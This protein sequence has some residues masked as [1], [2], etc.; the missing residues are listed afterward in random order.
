MQLTIR[1]E[2]SLNPE[3]CAFIPFWITINING[4]MS[5]SP[6][7]TV[8]I[9]N[10]GGLIKAGFASEESPRVTAPNCTAK[11]KNALQ[12]LVAEETEAAVRN[13]SQLL[14]LRPCDRGY[15]VNWPC[16][17]EVWRRMLGRQFLD[18]SHP[19]DNSVLVTV[20]PFNLPV[21]QED[22]TEVI[23]EE[24]G[25][26]ACAQIPAQRV[27]AFTPEAPDWS[28]PCL[29]VDSGFSF[30][31]SFPVVKGRA[32]RNAIQRLNV[33]GKLLTNYLKEMISYRQWNM[34]DDFRLVNEVKE[35]LC[36]VAQNFE[37]DIK[38]VRK[39][40]ATNGISKEFVLPD[41][42]TTMKGYVRDPNPVQQAQAQE[43]EQVL[44]MGN[45]RFC[46]GEVL[47]RPSDIGLAQAGLAE[48]VA[49]SIKAS[50]PEYQGL[51]CSN[52]LL[53]GG[54]TLMPNFKDR[55]KLELRP[56][57]SEYHQI[58][59]QT[60]E[61]PINHTWKMASQYAREDTFY[62]DCGM[63][64]KQEY[65]DYGHNICYKRFDLW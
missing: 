31:H 51:L 63:V 27:A 24:F 36:Y 1:I 42:Q 37:K 30:T 44:R 16:E 22:M 7:K 46:V 23:F 43:Y 32:A 52:I 11:I 6:E 33:G 47:F 55:L 56:L 20:P 54:N 65:E 19:S 8:V 5:F 34:M 61:D 29:V 26:G 62:E 40:A 45:E 58:K 9:D 3:D 17:S 28:R 4:Q 18:V 39:P 21:L 64:Q 38:E 10:G 35:A 57:V 13:S 14:Y 12:T 2:L 53:V 15:L 50:P 59:I 48:T 25:F 49:R 41:Y 60:V